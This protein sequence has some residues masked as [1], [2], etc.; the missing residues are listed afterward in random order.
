MLSR[1]LL[2]RIQKLFALPRV[3][4]PESIG[5]DLR[6]NKRPPFIGPMSDR[7]LSRAMREVKPGP[8]PERPLQ[9]VARR[10]REK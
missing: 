2:S 3:A 1:S 6:T 7:E 10:T 4:R 8:A 9:K 5:S